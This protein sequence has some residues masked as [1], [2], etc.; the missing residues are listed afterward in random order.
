[1]PAPNHKLYSNCAINT[2]LQQTEVTSAAIQSSLVFL[3]PA[4]SINLPK[5]TAPI[6]SPSLNTDSV[7]SARYDLSWLDHSWGIVISNKG[8]NRPALQA[9]HKPLVINKG[10]MASMFGLTIRVKIWW[11]FMVSRSFDSLCFT[12][13]LKRRKK[14]WPWSKMPSSPSRR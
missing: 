2:Q 14:N 1:M 6:I 11:I 3:K 8:T 13:I 9:I 12:G 4:R 10:K 5:P 7:I